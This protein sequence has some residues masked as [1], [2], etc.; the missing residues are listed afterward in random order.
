MDIIEG[1]KKVMHDGMLKN[2]EVDGQVLPIVFFLYKEEDKYK[3]V[4][5]ALEGNLMSDKTY[6]KAIAFALSKVCT[7]PNIVAAG[8]ITEA[9]G[10]KLDINDS[11]AKQLLDGE[12]TV[13]ELDEKDDLV[14]LFFS[15]P[16]S[17]EVIVYTVDVKNKSIGEKYPETSNFIGIFSGLFGWKKK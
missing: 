16:V 2:F 17:E 11:V 8:V 3:P 13:S 1:F 6:K 14:I 5:A 15:T 7:N 12:I 9:Y 10:A 4:F